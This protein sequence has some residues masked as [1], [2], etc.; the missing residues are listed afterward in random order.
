MNINK[1]CYII[2]AKD[3]SS[4]GDTEPVN[5]IRERVARELVISISS[6]LMSVDNPEIHLFVS[7]KEDFKFLTDS[8]SGLNIHVHDC[9]LDNR[10]SHFSKFKTFRQMIDTVGEC[11]YI[12]RSFKK[13]TGF[14]PM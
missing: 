10:S 5:K 6:L 9:L 8:L 14:K 3:I 2:W 11:F 4:L 7:P 12:I 1:F 13:T